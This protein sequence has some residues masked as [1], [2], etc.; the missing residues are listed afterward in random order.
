M[1]R[2]IL[3]VMVTAAILLLPE[4]Q[5]KD[6]SHLHPVQLLYIYKE[7]GKIVLET[8]M[9][10]TGKGETLPDALENLRATSEGELFLETVEYLLVTEETKPM[11]LELGAI[12]RPATNLVVA[13]TDVNIE[14]VVQY[15]EIHRPEVTLLD[16]RTGVKELPELVEKEGRCCLEQQN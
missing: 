13:L 15:L 3:F 4:G 8:D 11:I 14:K 7:D 5:E 10:D 16:Y 1:K 9:D 6:I 12:L 2:W